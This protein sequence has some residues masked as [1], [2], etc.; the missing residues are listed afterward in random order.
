MC[1]GSL[2]LKAAASLD[3]K[4]LDLMP[5]TTLDLMVLDLMAPAALDLK[6][7]T[8]LEDIP[9]LVSPLGPKKL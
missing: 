4:V 8:S 3:L 5:P 7:P 6:V 2:I 9:C 1:D